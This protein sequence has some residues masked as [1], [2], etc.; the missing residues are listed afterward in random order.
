M[1]GKP[2]INVSLDRRKEIKTG[3]HAGRYHIKVWVTFKVAR[4][5][6]KA[7]NQQPYLTQ[8]FATPAEFELIWGKNKPRRSDLL[9]ICNT[10]I[11]LESKAIDIVEKGIWDQKTFDLLYQSEFDIQ[12]MAGQFE[13]KIALLLQEDKEKGKEPRLSSAEKYRTAINSFM[14]FN[15][16]IYG[17]GDVT[18]NEV[19]KEWCEAYQE[20]YT[21]PVE[22]GKKK[23]KRKSVTSVGINMRCLRHIFR[24][25]IDLR[26]IPETLYPFGPGGYIIPEGDPEQL[27]NFLDQDEKDKFIKHQSR[28][29]VVAYYHDFA[30]FI[31]Y[32]NGLNIADM[33]SLKISNDFK[34]YLSIERIKTRG[35]LKKIK[36][37]YIPVHSVMRDV[38]VRWG[39]KTLNPNDYIFPILNNEMT[40]QERKLAI[41]RFN[42]YFNNACAKIAKEI[43]LDKKVQ[44]YTLRHT[45]SFMM[46]LQGASTEILQDNLGHGSKLTTEK[47]K[48]R[49]TMDVK[50]KFSE[51]L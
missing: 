30:R 41:K 23:G 26:I 17:H 16:E 4:G 37:I 2:T 32:G 36:R 43:G 46:L 18:F 25:A 12:T 47:Y 39:N 33:L 44:S 40:P 45:H 28:D 48:H 10:L 1:F 24:Q 50:K 8:C 42:K 5:G 51:G 21:K 20:W 15:K 19:N 35:K 14:E 9:E 11:K 49:F 22:E 27:D 34:E 6:K 31:Y 13:Y 29:G 7:W 38:M 3:E